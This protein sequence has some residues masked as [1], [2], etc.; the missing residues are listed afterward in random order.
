MGGED[1]G[2][3]DESGCIIGLDA[4]SVLEVRRGFTRAI[5]LHE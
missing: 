3:I 1:E 2:E 5:F 4:Q